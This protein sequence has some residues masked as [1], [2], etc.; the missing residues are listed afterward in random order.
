MWIIAQPKLPP[1]SISFIPLNNLRKYAP[2]ITVITKRLTETQKSLVTFLRSHSWETASQDLTSSLSD[3]VSLI[4]ASVPRGPS[5]VHIDTQVHAGWHL[6]CSE[7]CPLSGIC[8]KYQYS[9]TCIL[10]ESPYPRA[11]NRPVPYLLTVAKNLG[12]AAG[13]PGCEA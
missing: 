5:T 7:T 4:I 9:G 1:C 8:V 3:S 2:F 12:S 11:C 10:K 6:S 13:L